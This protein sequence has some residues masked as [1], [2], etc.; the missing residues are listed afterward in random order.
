[1]GKTE[2]TDI[3]DANTQS[4]VKLNTTASGGFTIDA[5]NITGILGLDKNDM[6]KWSLTSTSTSTS[7]IVGNGIWYIIPEGY[8]RLNGTIY[9]IKGKFRGKICCSFSTDA[10][11]TIHYSGTLFLRIR[12]N[13]VTE[14]VVIP[15]PVSD[16]LSGDFST[17]VDDM[18]SKIPPTAWSVSDATSNLVFNV[19]NALDSKNSVWSTNKKKG[20]A[21]AAGEAAKGADVFRFNLTSALQQAAGGEPKVGGWASAFFGAPTAPVG[22]ATIGAGGMGAQVLLPITATVAPAP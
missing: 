19:L 6:A 22:T 5:V 15:S 11:N 4:G 20:V 2:L 17:D 9:G 18:I 13:G 14:G 16:K 7:N 3:Y 8:L 10:D 21:L 12:D 1:M